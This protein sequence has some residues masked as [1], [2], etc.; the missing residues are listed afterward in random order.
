MNYIAELVNLAKRRHE[1]AARA[2]TIVQ[3]IVDYDGSEI[4]LKAERQ[5]IGEYPFYLV[6]FESGV[7]KVNII[8]S[9]KE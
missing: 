5:Y 1:N 7:F 6:A 8:T 9:I 4:L 2:L 3:N